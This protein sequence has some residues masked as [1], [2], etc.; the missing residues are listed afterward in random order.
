MDIIAQPTMEGCIIDVLRLH[1]FVRVA[2]A[3][4]AQQAFDDRYKSHS[5][6]NLML[7]YLVNL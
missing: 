7:V 3:A 1:L 6:K 2:R 4:N 5:L